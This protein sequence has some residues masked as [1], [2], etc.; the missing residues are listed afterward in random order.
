[1]NN[2]TIDLLTSLEQQYLNAKNIYYNTGESIMSDSEFDKLEEQ[3]KLLNPQSKVL[4]IVGYTNKEKIPLPYPMMSLDKKK[5]QKDLD[6]WLKQSFITDDIII[7]DKLDGVSIMLEYYNNGKKLKL[8]TRGNGIEGSNITKFAKYLNIP[9]TLEQDMII[10]GEIILSNKIFKSKY[11]KKFENARNLVS[12]IINKKKPIKEMLNDLDIITYEL[13]FPEKIVYS[14][15]LEIL[16]KTGFKVVPY[17]TANKK[18]INKNNLTEYLKERLNSSNYKIDGIVIYNDSS[19]SISKNRNPKYA[20]AFK[21]T[22]YNESINVIV[23]NIEWNVSKHGYLKPRILFDSIRLDGVNVKYT[24]GFNAK[25]IKDN[26][27]GP[28]TILK[29]IRSGDVIPHILEVVKSTNAQ[30]PSNINYKWHSNNYE[31]MLVNSDS[32]EQIIKQLTDSF[33]KIKVKGL[34]VAIIKKL[35]NYGADNIIKI[36]NMSENDFLKLPNFKE[37]L[38]KKIYN[39]IQISYNNASLNDIM[40]FSNKFGEGFGKKRIDL[41]IKE[42]PEII[43]II[44]KKEIDIN[45][46]SI[47]KNIENISGFG[48]KTATLFVSNLISFIKFYNKLPK[49]K[50]KKIDNKTNID[51]YNNLTMNFKHKNVVFSGMT[52]RKLEDTIKYMSGYIQ[53]NVNNKTDILIVKSLDKYTTKFKKAQELNKVIIEYKNLFT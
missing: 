39:N 53:D 36:L 24:T 52:D 2:S 20:F 27:I 49:Q 29:I 5:E 38:A 14:K 48:K 10:R 47:L 34:D 19:Y 31:I 40:N 3:I 43:N 12:G 16:H 23:K 13:Y 37:T 15:Q 44:K 6:N 9:Q 4:N 11:S 8:Y 32:P 25:Y 42:Y 21:T 33:K 51:I 17:F 41:I 35:Y 26:N 45:I 28:G 22:L 30:L 50:N 7:S 18:T 1:M 46:D